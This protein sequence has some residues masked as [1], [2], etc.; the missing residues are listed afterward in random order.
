MTEKEIIAKRTPA[1]GWTKKQ[2]AEWGI[3]WPPPRGWKKKLI[4]KK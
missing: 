1:G 4:S 3:P 2:L